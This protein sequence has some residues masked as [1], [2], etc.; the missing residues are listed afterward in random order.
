MKIQFDAHQEYQLQAIDAAVSVFEGLKTEYQELE[1]VSL[2]PQKNGFA[3]HD[4]AVKNTCNLVPETVLENIKEIQEKNKITLGIVENEPHF[5]IEMETGTGKTY[6]YLRTIHELHKKYGF[7]KFIIVVPSIAI[8]QGVLKNLEITEKHFS[9]LYGAPS[10]E[11]FVYDSRKIN[12]LRSFATS[13]AV[14]IMVMNIDAFRKSGTVIHKYNDSLGERPI[15]FIKATSPIVIVDEPQNM[16]SDKAK[17]ALSELNPLCTFRYSATHRNYYNLLYSLNPV[18][19]YDLGLVKQIEV[20]SVR[21]DNSFNDTYIEVVSVE[22]QARYLKAKLKIEVTTREGVK[23]KVF[24]VTTQAGKVFDLFD[25]SSEREQYKGYIVGGISLEEKSVSFTNAQKHYQGQVVGEY[26]DQIIRAQIRSTIHEHFRKEKKLI[27]Q[28]VKVLSLFFLD[29]VVNYRDYEVADQKGKYA[30]WFEEFYEEARLLPEYQEL[31]H[32]SV[33]HVHAGYFSQDKKG[34]YKD[35][36]G[37]SESDNST[38]ELIMNKKEQL[39][40]LEEPLKFIFSHSALREGWDNPNVF[41]ICTLNETTSEMKKRQEIGRGLRLPVDQTGK[42]FI[43][44]PNILT[45]MRTLLKNFR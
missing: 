18:E 41:Q 23:K 29:R 43:L 22:R 38:Y 11:Y 32:P 34:V 13:N 39:L 42:R 8:R 44:G 2:L 9:D 19:A 36:R 25:L 10:L 21:E 27:S 31:N 12:R 24:V 7:K 1:T 26:A 5:S 20:A 17:E 14:Q 15:E 16:E 35:T 37:D 3:F 28:G 33:E 40:S 6:V 4:L 30:K 45:V